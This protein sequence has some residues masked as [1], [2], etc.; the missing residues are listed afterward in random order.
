MAKKNL[1][2]FKKY[3][4]A[5]ALKSYSWYVQYTFPNGLLLE[6]QGWKLL[7]N[8]TWLENAHWTRFVSN[9]PLCNSLNQFQKTKNKKNLPK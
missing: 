2:S 8:N 4:V 9:R 3:I 5:S 1:R 6:Q 7:S